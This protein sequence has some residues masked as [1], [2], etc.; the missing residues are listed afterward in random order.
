MQV[1]T[2]NIANYR[3]RTSIGLLRNDLDRVLSKP[4]KR[5]VTLELIKHKLMIMPW[6]LVLIKMIMGKKWHNFMTTFLDQQPDI[7]ENMWQESMK[8]MVDGKDSVDPSSAGG[9]NKDEMAIFVGILDSIKYAP[10][11][12]IVIQ[13]LEESWFIETNLA[14]VVDL[15]REF[16]IA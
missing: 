8:H 6:W 5:I 12:R 15:K 4:Q 11:N 7:L 3:N 14:S 13:A 1:S 9:F 16:Q 2:V 10:N